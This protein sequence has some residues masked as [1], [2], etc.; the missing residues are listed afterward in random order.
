M[1]ANKIKILLGGFLTSISLQAAVADYPSKAINFVVPY[2]PGG[3]TDISSR[4]LTDKLSKLKSWNFIVENKAGAAGSVGIAYIARQKPDGYQIAMGQTSNLTIN[5]NLN[6]AI[7]YNPLEDFTP[8]TIVGSQ[9]TVV[10][11]ANNSQ[12]TNFEEILADAKNGKTLTMGTPGIGTVSHLSIEY[13]AQLADIKIRHIPYPGAT[14]AIT[15]AMGGHLSFAATSLPS[16]L[17][18]IRAGTMRPLIVTSKERNQALPDVPTVAELGFDDFNVIEWKAVIGPAGMKDSEVNTLNQAINEALVD[19][20]FIEAM[21]REGSDPVGGSS[22]E[23]RKLL[24]D[25]YVRWKEVSE[26]AG[27]IK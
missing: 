6:K 11:V 7:T 8:I 19:P 3:G 25:E 24:E 22:E 20:E 18:H 9:P 17:S 23:F 14:P 12:Y 10:V 26:N 27:L 4:L 15:E 13:L 1:K 2:P 16:A 5:P 21:R